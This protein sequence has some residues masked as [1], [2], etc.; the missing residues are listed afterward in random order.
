MVSPQKAKSDLKKS[1][2][3]SAL[4][5]GD[6]PQYF[7]ILCPD[8]TRTQR[9]ID[10][11]TEKWPAAE[12]KK[13]KSQEL[14]L[15]KLNELLRSPLLFAPTSIIVIHD[16]DMIQAA[17]QRDLLN[18]IE[19]DLHEKVSF[20]GCL[21]ITAK[22][23]PSNNF[24]LKQLRAQERTIELKELTGV[25][26]KKWVFKELSAKGFSQIADGV[27]ELLIQIGEE[28]PDKVVP[29]IHHLSL[30]VEMPALSSTDITNVFSA[31][32]HHQEFA[33]LD[34]LL[35]RN[36]IKGE[37]MVRSLLSDGK[38]P[39]LLISLLA[40]SF[41]TYLAIQEGLKKGLQP[42]QVR[43]QL[44]VSPWVFQKYLDASRKYSL[45][46]LRQIQKAV[47]KADS[48]LKNKSL[49]DEGIL[50]CLLAELRPERAMTS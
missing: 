4:T 45:P 18:L 32:T 31:Q 39:F 34:T 21:I 41:S 5:K 19:K 11:A 25:E 44:A 47:V 29:L 13:L 8:N 20:N 30:A 35:D 9:A 2:L 40:K 23:L 15:S 50:C 16:V 49:G 26:L 38:N 43:E 27:P 36:P 3:K 1:D 12:I 17:A 22:T 10:L 6:I 33:L 24:F 7:L 48:R 28:N 42:A 37:V 46:R 14:D